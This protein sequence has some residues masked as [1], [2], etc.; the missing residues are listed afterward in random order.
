[1]LARTMRMMRM[2]RSV[3]SCLLVG[4]TR[5]ATTW[6]TSYRGRLISC[7]TNTV[8]HMPSLIVCALYRS[9][10]CF[11][12]AQRSTGVG[13]KVG[14]GRGVAS[15]WRFDCRSNDCHGRR[16]SRACAQRRAPCLCRYVTADDLPLVRLSCFKLRLSFTVYLTRYYFPPAQCP[17]TYSMPY[18]QHF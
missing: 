2:I 1:M 5:P 12:S 6:S 11:G 17:S 9:S 16:I 15:C 7:G 18:L 8:V 14:G 13:L 4:L 3:S 10:F